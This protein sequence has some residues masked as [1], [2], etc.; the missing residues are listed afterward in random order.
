MEKV[1]CPLCK[2]S[3]VTVT[4]IENMSG[5]LQQVL[6]WHTVAS[7]PEAGIIAR[8]NSPHGTDG[9]TC[10]GTGYALDLAECFAADIRA[11]IQLRAHP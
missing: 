7:A 5:T 4:D 1:K 10:L 3:C 2:G 11:G 8:S 9:P 6:Q